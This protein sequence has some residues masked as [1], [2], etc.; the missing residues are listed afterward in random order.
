MHPI[1]ESALD[2]AT[3]EK[4]NSARAQRTL[5]RQR[6]KPALWSHRTS[7]R[8]NGDSLAA[9]RMAESECEI[10]IHSPLRNVDPSMRLPS[11]MSLYVWCW[12]HGYLRFR[13]RVGDTTYVHWLT[14]RVERLDDALGKHGLPRCMPRAFVGDNAQPQHDSILF[15]V[16]PTFYYGQS[17]HPYRK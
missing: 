5:A 2:D 14:A 16:H 1:E 6:P 12:A 3:L 4:T 8:N 13:A 9:R 15:S 17:L 11:S 7:R 10:G